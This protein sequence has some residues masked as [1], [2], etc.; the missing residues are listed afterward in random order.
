MNGN[1]VVTLTSPSS[2]TY[3][4]I[5]FMSDRTV[6]QS[7]KQQEWTTI[8]GSATLNYQGVMYLPEQQI[9]A[10]GTINAT[11]PSMAILADQVWWQGNQKTTITVANPQN[12]PVAAAPTFGIGA[13]LV[14]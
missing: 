8:L 1:S 13:R 12:L 10:E 3:M 7:K 9:W 11:S 6:S 4:N 14:N 2:G 5:Q